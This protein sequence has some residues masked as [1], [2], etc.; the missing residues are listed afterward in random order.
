MK[1]TFVDYIEDI[2]ESIDLI[3]NGKADNVGRFGIP[4]RMAL[5]LPV[6]KAARVQLCDGHPAAFAVQKSKP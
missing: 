1:R 6:Y 2:V 4:G 3:L 5:V